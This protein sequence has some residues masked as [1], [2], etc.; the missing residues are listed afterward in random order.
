[1]TLWSPTSA[2]PPSAVAVAWADA[3]HAR[4]TWTQPSDGEACIEREQDMALLIWCVPVAAGPQ[5][6]ALAPDDAHGAPLPGDVYTVTADGVLLGEVALGPVVTATWTSFTRAIVTWPADAGYVCVLRSRDGG[7]SW[8]LMDCD[9][10]GDV[11]LT[12]GGGDAFFAPAY[13][14]VYRVWDGAASL[15]EATLGWPPGTVWLPVVVT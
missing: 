12:V 10:D 9:D 11:A 1:M 2:A 8:W 3:S 14:D 6:V 13:G 5:A 7:A 4:L 15:G